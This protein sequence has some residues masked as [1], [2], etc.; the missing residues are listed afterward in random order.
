MKNALIP[1]DFYQL[2]T[3]SKPMVE[4]LIRMLKRRSGLMCSLQPLM[5]TMGKVILNSLGQDLKEDDERKIYQESTN[6]LRELVKIIPVSLCMINLDLNPI[7]ESTLWQRDHQLR[8]LFG[9]KK[10]LENQSFYKA[11]RMS[12]EGRFQSHEEDLWTLEGKQKWV[13]WEMYP[14]LSNKNVVGGVVI[15]VE[16]ITARKN[17]EHHTSN[18]KSMKEQLESVA[19][20]C[21]HDMQAYIR[22][23]SSFLEL[24]K[25]HILPHVDDT[26]QTYIDF[27]QKSIKQMQDFIRHS[28]KYI[29]PQNGQ[30]P[31]KFFPFD[32]VVK[33][34]QVLFSTTLKEENITLQYERLPEIYGIEVELRQVMQNLLSNAIKYS[35]PY[36][37]IKIWVEEGRKEWT[38][39]VQDYGT[40]IQE[41]D[42]KKIFDLFY[43]GMLETQSQLDMTSSNGIGLAYCK[44]VIMLHGGEIGVDSRV[45]QGAKFHFSLPKPSDL[46]TIGKAF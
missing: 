26:A 44:Q 24:L 16:D 10:F 5:L 13:R 41:R 29:H 21:P 37:E 8:L 45:G 14:W 33:E 23:F 27:M 39:Y 35:P 2:S 4:E 9:E 22:S 36:S 20:I 17:L 30:H 43:R 19:Y 11:L 7:A 18:L 38:I 42:Q 12:L 1:I 40:G 3:S 46:E 32:H 28:L 15:F 31:K 25:Q 6:I 34:L